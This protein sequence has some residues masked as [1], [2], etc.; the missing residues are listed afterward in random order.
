MRKCGELARGELELELEL[1]LNKSRVNRLVELSEARDE[2]H[3]SLLDGDG[4]VDSM[5]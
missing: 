4:D 5:S 1:T 2:S 3:G